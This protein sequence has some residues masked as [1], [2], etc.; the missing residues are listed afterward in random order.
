MEATTMEATPEATEAAVER[1]EL[2]KEEINLDNI[3]S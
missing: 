1:Q 3:A 2:F